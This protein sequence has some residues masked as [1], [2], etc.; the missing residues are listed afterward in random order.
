MRAG[1]AGITRPGNGILTLTFTS[2][3]LA[4]GVKMLNTRHKVPTPKKINTV[5]N[6]GFFVI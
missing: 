6:N 2:A 3:L 4:I 1:G 5:F